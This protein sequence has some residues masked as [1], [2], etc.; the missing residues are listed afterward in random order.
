LVL[1]FSLG[2]EV[3]RRCNSHCKTCNLWRYPAGEELS[4]DEINRLFNS[5]GKSLYWITLTGGEPFLREDLVEICRI[6]YNNC[7]PKFINISTNGSLPERIIKDV[8]KILKFCPKTKFKVNLSFDG[9]GENHDNIRGLTKAFDFFYKTAQGLLRIRS[10]QLHIG[11]NTVISN[12]NINEI[13]N[14]ITFVKKNF[15]F[16]PFF[17]IAQIRDVFKNQGLNEILPKPEK[18]IS[19]FKKLYKLEKRKKTDLEE[20]IIYRLRKIYYKLTLDTLYLKQQIIPCFSGFSSVYIIAD[21]KVWVCCNLEKLLG[22]L[23]HYDFDFKKLW[24]SK[25]AWSVRKEIK[26]SNCFCLGVNANYLNILHSPNY[27]IKYLYG[28]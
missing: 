25:K 17:E 22:D 16:L 10:K 6:I 28:F 8:E 4:L 19:L 13:E 24:W 23:K 14:I 21:G 2:F 26:E 1:P 27:L 15:G 7:K 18:S 12:Y 5:L 9:T 11:I 20:T 3:T